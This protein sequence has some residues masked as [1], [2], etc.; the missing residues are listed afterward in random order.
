MKND[1]FVKSN[2]IISTILI[3]QN[4][5]N[6]EGNFL[7]SVELFH[8]YVKQALR[9]NENNG[10]PKKNKFNYNKFF[11]LFSQTKNNPQES[12]KFIRNAY[13]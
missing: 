8:N 3:K 1:Y 9:V 7:L 2:A 12:M 6:V 5:K 13:Y 10:L 4:L 11:S